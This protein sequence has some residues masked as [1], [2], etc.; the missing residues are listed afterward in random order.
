M[1]KIFFL[2]LVWSVIQVSVGYAAA[3]ATVSFYPETKIKGPD[4]LLGD[5]ARITS[6]DANRIEE[7]KKVK[8]GNA[9][10]P[11]AKVNFSARLL[12]LRLVQSGKDCQNVVW[13][14]PQSV[15]VE[16]RG[17]EIS[18]EALVAQVKAFLLS[19]TAEK[20]EQREHVWE[21][22]NAP[23]AIMAPEGEITY[24]FQLPY[25]IRNGFPTNV[26]VAVK[27]D[28]QLYK[29][30]IVRGRL[31]VYEPI[32]VAARP[33]AT[34]QTVQ[35]EDVTLERKDVT[36]FGR[37]Y[38]SRPEQVVGMVM[39]RMVGTG[40]PLVP[41]MLDKPIVV[42][43]LALVKIVSTNGAIRIE[44]DGQALQDGRENDLIRVKNLNSNK[45]LSARVVDETTVEISLR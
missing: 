17:N 32:I 12:Q 31:H 3:A 40:A 29:K 44:T 21:M 23:H 41:G 35:P 16:T 22:L 39:K 28:G 11:G 45:V 10:A 34:R 38:F 14:I 8:L 30:T 42:K 7:L 4:I 1:K 15:V 24:D 2:C 19:Q 36:D 26:N 20:G 43:R 33:L 5:I 25:P 6:E 9:A 18:G 27:V 37:G 13:D